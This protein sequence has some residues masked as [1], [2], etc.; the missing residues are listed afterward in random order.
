MRLLLFDIDGTL[1]RGNKAGRTAMA[2]A[3]TEMFGTAGPLGSYNMSGKTDAKIVTDLLTA[4]GVDKDEIVA[5]L[6]AV[7]ELMAQK[8]HDVYPGHGIKA[9]LGI[10]ALLDD[11]RNREDVVLG[12]LTGN[13]HQTAP[14]K[15]G[16][17]GV[18][19]EQFVV[20]AYGS[21][22]LDR[23]RL[24]QIALQ[25]ANELTGRH[26]TGN[27]TTI[28][29]DTPADIMC[30]RAGKATAVAVAT[31][32]HSKAELLGHNPDYLFADFGDT[33]S[34]VRALLDG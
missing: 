24:P 34:V 14:L 2:L 11:L 15:I 32:W 1:I 8:A 19:P 25:R 26:L 6:P 5:S 21:D 33:Q 17:A 30:A 22:D 31:G 3:L 12:L 10:D 16:A 7:F 13:A 29:G 20:G 4:I 18:D 23:N 28:V 27:N 9:C